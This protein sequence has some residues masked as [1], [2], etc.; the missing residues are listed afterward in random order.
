MANYELG[1]AIATYSLLKGFIKTF[2]END[3]LSKDQAIEI[4]RASRL[5]VKIEFGYFCSSEDTFRCA[6]QLLET[7]ELSVSSQ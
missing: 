6:D 7:L 5:G 3:M 4:I 1:S 2:I